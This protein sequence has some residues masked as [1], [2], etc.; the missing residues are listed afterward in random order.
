MSVSPYQKALEILAF[1]I[2]SGNFYDRAV[3]ALSLVTGHRWAGVFRLC[4]D[5]L[6]VKA[7]AFWVDGCLGG[8][9]SF[10]L[11]GTPCGCLYLLNN[12]TSSM[13]SIDHVKEQF[14]GF[15]L[16]DAD[17]YRA[18]LFFNEEGKPIGHIATMHDRTVKHS[19]VEKHFFHLLAQRIGAEFRNDELKESLFLRYGMIDNTTHMMS[20]VDRDYTY[21]IVSKGYEPVLGL[22]VSEIVN[23]HVRDVFGADLFDNTIKKKLD[24]CLLGETVHSAHWIYPRGRKSVYI[25]VNQSPFYDMNGKIVGVITSA[26]DVTEAKLNEDKVAEFAHMDT[27][28]GLPNRRYLFKRLDEELAKFKRLGNKSVVFFIDLD[29]FKNI[30]D[31]LGHAVG[32]TVLEIIAK[33]LTK[34]LRAEDVLARIG[35]DEFVLLVSSD[36]NLKCIIDESKLLAKKI[37]TE[38]TREIIISENSLSLSASIGIH[39]IDSDDQSADDIIRIADLAMYKAKQNG[40]GRALIA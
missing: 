31:S 12:T 34:S 1:K 15:D 37:L 39:A 21:R 4:P 29:G 17:T 38:I 7:E 16:L 9:F 27:L 13:F 32:D 40:R 3:E 8:S 6:E 23:R 2:G 36:W 10:P 35:G 20:F 30:N 18:A 19:D 26:H 11:E 22:P 25:D 5:K 24:L 14:P 28:T 33:R